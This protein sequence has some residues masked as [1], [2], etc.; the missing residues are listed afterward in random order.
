[1]ADL[2]VSHTVPTLLITGPP[3]VGKTSVCFEILEILEDV[4][5]PHAFVDAELTY[6]YP[7][8]P[9]DPSGHGVALR[10][11]QALWSVYR[12]LG[13]PRLILARVLESRQH[14]DEYRRAVPG[15]DIQVFRLTAS[16]EV[17]AA[18]LTRRE[19]GSGIDWYLDRA[20]HLTRLWVTQSVEDYLVDTQA[21][22]V[23]EIAEEILRVSRWLDHPL[24]R[25]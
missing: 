7:K 10:G 20:A 13:A 15:A 12:E 16:L 18:R 22:S 25:Q 21:R 11:L 3:G 19:I 24:G 23:R 4:G 2:H 6:L 14:L 5:V 17:I 8:P 9:G 1:M